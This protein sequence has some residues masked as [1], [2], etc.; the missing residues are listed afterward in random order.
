MRAR[1]KVGK[2]SLSTKRGGPYHFT[3]RLHV[4][5]GWKRL[6][7]IERR[8]IDG[9]RHSAYSLTPD[10]EYILSGGL[11]GILRL[12]TLDGKTQMKL[13]GHVG[14][15]KAVAISADGQ[16]AVTGSNDQTVNLWSLDQPLLPTGA[17]I[18]PTLTL[19]PATDGEWVAWTPEGFLAAS[20]HGAQ[21]IGYS[22]NQGLDKVAKHIPVE[23]MYAHYYRPDL[24]VPP[25]GVD[26]AIASSDKG[27]TVAVLDFKT[28]DLLKAYGV[29]IAE[30]LRTEL[31]ALSHSVAAVP[32]EALQYAINARGLPSM[33]GALTDAAAIEVGKHVDADRVV[34]GSVVKFGSTV[35][36]NARAIDVATGHV[37]IA[38]SLRVN[39]EDELSSVSA[40]LVARNLLQTL[41]FQIARDQVRGS[42]LMHQLASILAAQPTPVR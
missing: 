22:I 39:H 31:A 15:I 1:R 8:D 33:S 24:V 9:H 30:I 25:S 36:V 2:L 13:V 41:P 11:N 40:V 32:R 26:D 29:G 12:Y 28:E 6:H 42:T 3:Y 35:T 17:A 10:G 5:R 38:R 21:L 14:E 34:V 4:K 37:K 16:W 18:S 20:A 27:E 7:T 19:F 23:Q